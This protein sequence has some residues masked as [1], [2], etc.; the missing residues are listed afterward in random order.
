MRCSKGWYGRYHQQ[1]SSKW[2]AKYLLK[3]IIIVVLICFF[4]FFHLGC[5][6]HFSIIE[7]QTCLIILGPKLT[8]ITLLECKV[9]KAIQFYLVVENPIKIFDSPHFTSNWL[10]SWSPPAQKVMFLKEV[11]LSSQL[12]TFWMFNNFGEIWSFTLIFVDKTLANLTMRN[13]L[14]FDLLWWPLL[15]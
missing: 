4:G 6:M 5:N 1:S 8:E 13:P 10:S 14:T 12:C 2:A 9:G 7:F 11:S 15:S 3:S